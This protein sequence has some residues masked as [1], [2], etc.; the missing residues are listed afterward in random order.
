ME[1][2]SNVQEKNLRTLQ[3]MQ[4]PDSRRTSIPNTN[5]TGIYIYMPDI[6]PCSTYIPYIEYLGIC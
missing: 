2:W 5:G 6:D 1:V 4:G 3:M